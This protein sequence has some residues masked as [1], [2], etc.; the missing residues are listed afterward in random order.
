MRQYSPDRIAA[1]WSGLP[2]E[3]G[4]A[5]G[6]FFVIRRNAPTWT[7]RQNGLGG[8]IRLFNPDRSGEVD[9]LINTESKTHSALLLLAT[10]D[11][12]T[13][14]IRAP[15]VVRDLNTQEIFVFTRAYI[16]TEPDEQR[17]TR[18]VEVTWTFAFTSIEHTPA[19]PGLNSVGS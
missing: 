2:L 8:T 7:Q 3:E 18:S 16:T 12:F 14:L 9:F 17:A 13:R 5:E 4:L 15:L 10:T 6:S 1:S 19:V 11:R